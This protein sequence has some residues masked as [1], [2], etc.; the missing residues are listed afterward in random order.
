MK[1][2]LPFERI[3]YMIKEWSEAMCRMFVCV[4]RTVAPRII[5]GMSTRLAMSTTTTLA[6][7]IGFR[8]TV[9][10]KM[11][12]RQA[13]NDCTACGKTQGVSLPCYI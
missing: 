12:Y 1:I 11:A 4:R 8:R 3:D 10:S 7:R 5:R 2:I 13:S 6:T 9:F